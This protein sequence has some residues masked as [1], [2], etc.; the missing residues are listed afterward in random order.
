MAVEPIAFSPYLRP[1]VWGGRNLAACLQKPL[2]DA[3]PYGESW[4][5]SGHPDHVTIA[6]SGPQCG[7]GLDQLWKVH[8]AGWTNG[9]STGTEPFPLLL[10]WLDC[11][12]LLSVQV[13][14]DDA[15]ARELRNERY[16]KTEAWIVVA[17]Q[18]TGRIFAG[19]K[20]GVTAEAL[21]KHLAAGTVAECLHSFVPHPGDC[22]FIPAGTVHAVGGGVL[23]AEVQQSSDA[24]FRLFDWNRPGS[25]GQPRPLHIEESLRAI[26]WEAGPVDPVVPRIV[27]EEMS[28]A[29]REKL[30]H[31][32]EFRMERWNLSSGELAHPFADELSL[33]MVLAGSGQYQT[34]EGAAHNVAAGHSLLIPAGADQMLWRGSGLTLLFALPTFTSI[35]A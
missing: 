1:Q 28:G 2:P 12:D 19:L 16:G 27:R 18:P 32:K 25:D 11:H 22:L 35:V 3:Q 4:E 34:S 13:H 29:L 6:A 31:C 23:M 8:A 24:T 33:V 5:I 17:A 20:P 30:V 21:R 9:R 10:K 14:P 7:Q 15:L 26:R